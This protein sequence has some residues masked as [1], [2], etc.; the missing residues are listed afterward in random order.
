MTLLEDYLERG[1]IVLFVLVGSCAL[2]A[3]LY[4]GCLYISTHIRWVP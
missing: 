1:I 4:Y 2:F 3:F